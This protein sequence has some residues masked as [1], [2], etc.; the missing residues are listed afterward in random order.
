MLGPQ[1][2]FTD[3]LSVVRALPLFAGVDSGVL[4]EILGHARLVKFDKGKVCLRQGEE[5]SRLYV[6][7]EGWV[8]TVKSTQDGRD[9]VLN[10][11]GQGDVLMEMAVAGNTRCPA[12]VQAA[13][14]V[15][16]LSLPVSVLREYLDKNHG[17][18]VKMMLAA[19]VQT[20]NLI[21]QLEQLMLRDAPQRVGWKARK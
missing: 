5:V 6:I 8:K 14:K 11:S 19:A 18:A 12:T 13:S 2:A 4:T 20:Q 1:L 10:L 15:R 3:S 16:L 17:I 9:L 7:L 21:G